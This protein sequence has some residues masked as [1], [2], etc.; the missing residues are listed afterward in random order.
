MNQSSER[1]D[2]RAAHLGL[3]GKDYIADK[4]KMSSFLG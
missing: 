3:L 4:R 2:L 1:W